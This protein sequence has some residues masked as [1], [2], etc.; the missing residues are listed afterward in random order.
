MKKQLPFHY[1]TTAEDVT[2]GELDIEVSQDP[3]SLIFSLLRAVKGQAATLADLRSQLH[4][5]SSDFVNA[6]SSP[7]YPS[8]Y[9]P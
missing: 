9:L 4:K 8:S 1:L 5:R 2:G 3:N 6:L 7:G